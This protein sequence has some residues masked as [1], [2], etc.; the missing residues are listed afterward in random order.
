[1]TESLLYRSERGYVLAMRALYGRHYEARHRAV[2]N[3]VPARAEVL[4]VCCGPATIWRRYLRAKEVRYHGLDINPRF[5]ERLRGLGVA[6]EVWDVGKAVPLP[7][8]DVVIMQA[9]L[10][11]F[12]PDPHPVIRRMLTAAREAVVISEPVRNLSTSPLFLLAGLGRRLTRVGRSGT[13]RFDEQTLDAVM[14]RYQSA[15][16][17]RF[18]IPGG[19]EKVYVLRPASLP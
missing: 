12:L 13:A 19:R 8:A 5:I 17:E 9:S 1:M 10:Y 16:S 7:K 15:V 2:A 6:A 14:G 11:H 4:D 18:L 3:L